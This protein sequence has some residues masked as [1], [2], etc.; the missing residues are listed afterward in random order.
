VRFRG[1]QAPIDN[2]ESGLLRA[3]NENTGA[4]RGSYG[5]WGAA[6]CNC[7]GMGGRR[8]LVGQGQRARLQFKASTMK[9]AN[10]GATKK[11]EVA[12]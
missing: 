5:D 8:G 12:L 10:A 9:I 6:V 4:S 11:R 1:P 2:D 3:A 7:W